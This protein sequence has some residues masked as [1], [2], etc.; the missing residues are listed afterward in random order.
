MRERHFTIGTLDIVRPIFQ[1]PIGSL[2]T[3]ELVATVSNAGGVGFLA[4]SWA[5]A[6]IATKAHRAHAASSHHSRMA[7]QDNDK[8]REAGKLYAQQGK[9][10][11]H[12]AIGLHMTHMD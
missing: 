4:L 6:E 3:A 8:C 7:N 10:H 12:E 1:A 5:D 2:V 9:P 11:G